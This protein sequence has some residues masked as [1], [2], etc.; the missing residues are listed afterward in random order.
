MPLGNDVRFACRQL[1]KSPGFTLIVLATLGLCIG[2]NTAI[3]SV[4]DAVLLR[5]APYPEPERLALLI[6]HWTRDGQEGDLPSQNAAMF[7]GVRDGVPDLD[8]AAYSGTNGANFASQGHLEYVRQQRVSAGYFRVLGMPP[9][10]GRE[11]TRQEDVPG[12]AAV[13]VLSYRFWQRVFQ[14][15]TGALG[16]AINLRGEPYTVIGIM[17]EDFRATAPVDVWTPLRPSRNGE[18]NGR[19]YGV[20][21]RIKQS[22]TWTTIS[23]QLRAISPG[24]F[25]AANDSRNTTIEQRIIPLQSGLT[26]NVRQELL[27]VW[28]AVLMVLLIGCVNIAGLLLA[29]SGARSREIATR[30]ALGG[31]RAAIVR[32]LLVESLLLALGGGVLGAGIGALALDWL[33]QLGA[34]SFASWHPIAIDLRVLAATMGIAVL[35]SVVCGLLPALSTARL[36]IRTVL[37]EGGRGMAGGRRHWSRNM[38]VACEVALSLVLLVGAGLL[39]RTLSYLNGLNPGFDPHNVLTAEVSLQDARYK[40]AASVSRLYTQSLER[41]RRIPGTVSAAAALTL[42]YERP[43]NDGFRLLEGPDTQRHGV[44]VVYATA[45]YFETLRIPLIAGRT[46][47]ESDSLEATKVAIVSQSFV[48]RYL[49]GQDALGRTIAGPRVI[50]GV[51][52]DVQQHSGLGNFGPISIEPTLYVPVSQISD[53]YVQ[54]IHTWFAPKWIIRNSSPIGGLSAQVQAAV[55]TADPLLPIAKFRT[56]DELQA[57]ITSQERYHAALFSILAGL[58]LLLAAIG[59]YGLISQSITQR[60]HEL[61]IRLALGATASQA[62]GQAMRPG[63]LL[64]AVGVAAGCGLSFFTVRFL[65]HFLWGV[66]PTDP[67]TFAATAALLLLVAAVASLVPALRI[68][69]L[70]PARTLRSE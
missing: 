9:Q 44:E 26:R 40:T 6:S 3:F 37:M 64:S 57:R 19:N 56:F 17:P 48:N 38:L 15:D 27:I 21:G 60:T 63:I 7:E 58:A 32:Q 53:A 25:P 30:M 31:G 52:G 59:L 28:A 11:F 67:A 69:R 34:D 24:L 13:A 14:G 12:G 20:V 33:K 43:L 35:T 16:R 23:E 41:I 51:V 65:K 70:D 55:A 5:G 39:V 45:G 61:G 4:L 46:F 66:R 47:R 10:I 22:A 54:V 36:D 29:R 2:A 68:L 8:V 62:I 42:P 49:R 50:V 18:G 1:R